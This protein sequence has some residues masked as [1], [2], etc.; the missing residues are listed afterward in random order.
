MIRNYTNR[1]GYLS[2]PEA[3][4]QTA[5]IPKRVDSKERGQ[6]KALKSR[7]FRGKDPDE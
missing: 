2:F 6:V 7:Y 5:G 4:P 3:L 1:R